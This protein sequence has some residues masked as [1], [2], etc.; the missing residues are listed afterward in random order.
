MPERI[1][2]RDAKFQQAAWTYAVY[3]VLYWLGGV[4]LVAGGLRP[5]VS[6][7]AVAALFAVGAG[8]V[9]LVPWLLYRARPW[10][11]R[12]VLSRRDFARLV[13]LFVAFRAFEVARI[14]WSP[15]VELVSV[16]GFAIPMRL[17]A[18]AFFLVTVVMVVMLARAAW[19]RS[20]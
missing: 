5:P 19:S 11:E 13:T 17:G 7:V 2:T 9:V 16:G 14:A 4:L 18:A 20:S 1:T 3:G 15:R 8:V 10:F 6:D 12:W